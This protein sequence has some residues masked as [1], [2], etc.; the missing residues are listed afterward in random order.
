MEKAHQ[1]SSTFIA[2]I[3]ILNFSQDANFSLTA[4]SNLSW[5]P[6]RFFSHTPSSCSLFCHYYYGPFM[7]LCVSHFVC[8]YVII[9]PHP[10]VLAIL[11]LLSI[12]SLLQHCCR[13]RPPLV[14]CHLEIPVLPHIRVQ[15]RR[16]CSRSL[17][18][19]SGKRTRLQ[20]LE[21][22]QNGTNS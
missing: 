21:T 20:N 16:T 13:N 15:Y 8:Q 7:L 19:G 5:T 17:A 18:F 9:Q 6:C 2:F 10:F 11:V 14:L 3:F 22:G 1:C 4:T 12:C